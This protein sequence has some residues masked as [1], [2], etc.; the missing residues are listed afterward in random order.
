MNFL[1]FT[2]SN[3][4]RR[5]RSSEM[6]T[7]LANKLATPYTIRSHDSAPESLLTQANLAFQNIL[8]YEDQNFFKDDL[9]TTGEPASACH[10][11]ASQ[12]PAAFS[13]QLRERFSPR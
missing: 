6:Q 11:R 9:V 13:L 1:T 8:A 3:V 2:T 5:G 12:C 10:G 4:S 7:G